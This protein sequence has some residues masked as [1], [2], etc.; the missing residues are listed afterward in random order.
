MRGFFSG[1]AKT[2]GRFSV[3]DF[4]DADSEFERLEEGLIAADVGLEIASELIAES[5]MRFQQCKE[6]GGGDAIKTPREFLR[7]VVAEFALPLESPLQ[8]SDA[9]PFVILVTGVNGVGKTTTIAK[10]A[11]RFI[12][13]GESVLLAAGDTFR[14]AAQEQLSVWANRLGDSADYIGGGGGGDPAAVAFDAVAAAVARKKRIAIV[15][16]AG[17]LPTQK[18][19]MEEMKKI[20]RAV[21]KAMPGAPHEVLLILDATVGQ[22]ALSQLKAFDDAL[23]ISGLIVAKLDGTARGG[24]LLALAKHRAKPV[25]FV[26]VG[27]NMEDLLPFES[28]L[29]ADALLFNSSANS[30]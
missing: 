25:R 5:R 2:R 17:R 4:A 21:N 28:R 6:G 24:A 19:L 18:H 3:S 29:F 22:N 1:L 11:K 27:E 14:A 30:A 13:S 26:G 16:T 20:H 12:N 10:L 9:N 15:D 8:L 23:H 7:E